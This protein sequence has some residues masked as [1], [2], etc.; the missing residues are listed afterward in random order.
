VILA[1]GKGT[2][3]WPYTSVLPK[4]LLPVGDRPILEI[5][6]GQLAHAGVSRATLAVGHMAH[7]FPQVLGRTGRRGMRIDYVTEKKPM[8]TAAP[9]RNISGLN[10][11]FLVLNGDILTDLDF[12]AL[13]RFHRQKRAVATIAT[14]RRSVGVDFGVIETNGSGLVDDYFEKPKLQY[15]VSMGVYVFEPGILKHIPR[16]GRFDF[17]DLVLRLLEANLPVASFPFRGRW[18]DI[19]RPDD[20]HAAQA[21]LARHPKRYSS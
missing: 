2:R 13:V 9:L 1:G 16:R 21:E 10:S 19:G 6:L 5:V 18:L 7:L 17:P 11:T 14:F 4:P 15:R 12:R 20:F 3:L 8:G